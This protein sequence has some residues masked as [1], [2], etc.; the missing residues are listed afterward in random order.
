M[1]LL[2]LAEWADALVAF[3]ATDAVRLLHSTL[4]GFSDLEATA[5]PSSAPVGGDRCRRL[6]PPLVR[7]P[8]T[9]AVVKRPASP[10]VLTLDPIDRIAG[11]RWVVLV[12]QTGHETGN[13]DHGSP[14]TPT[15]DR[16]IRH[17]VGHLE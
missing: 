10:H 6:G 8:R 12:G 13:S 9:L 16:Q 7:R 11:R 14:S 5:G 2:A 17:K 1:A 15:T 4:H 3:A